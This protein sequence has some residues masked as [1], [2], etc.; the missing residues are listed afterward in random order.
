MKERR[1]ILE[2]N[3]TVIPNKIMLSETNFLTVN[4]LQFFFAVYFDFHAQDFIILSMLVG[5]L[6]FTKSQIIY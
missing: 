5:S 2:K 6:P 3:V 4:D 1:K